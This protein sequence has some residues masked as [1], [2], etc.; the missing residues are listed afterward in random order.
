MAP[1]SSPEAI[2]LLF[3]GAIFCDLVFAGVSNPEAGTE[4]YAEGFAISPGGAANPAVA[5]ARLGRRTALLSELG[6]DLLGSTIRGTLAAEELLEVTWIAERHG[7]QTPVTAAMTGPHDRRFVTYAEDECNLDWPS[8]A[9]PVG[10]AH[11]S[12]DGNL[13]P[14]VQRLRAAGTQIYGGVGWDESGLWSEGVLERL[15]QVDVF[16]PNDLEAMKYTRTHTAED[17]ARAL[18]AYV[19]LAVVTRG[20]DGAIAYER[21]TDRLYR[22]AAVPM[23]AADPTGA[24]DVFVAALMSSY[25]YGWDLTERLRL[26]NLCAALS[27]QSLGGARSAPTIGMLNRFLSSQTVADEDLLADDLPEGDQ[28]LTVDWQPGPEWRDLSEWLR[29]SHMEQSPS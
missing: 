11:V 17:A 16:V 21:S 26:A 12:V 28:L 24:G 7:Y 13:R 20:R 1:A 4:V 23:R 22:S 18:G 27:V 8:A 15:E 25:D 29:H 19:D 10:A 6:D 9:P 5:A 2:D 14:W 3:T